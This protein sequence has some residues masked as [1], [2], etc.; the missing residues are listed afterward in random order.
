V[1]KRFGPIFFCWFFLHSSA[2]SKT[3]VEMQQLRLPPT[4]KQLLV[5]SAKSVIPEPHLQPIVTVNGW[6]Q[7]VRVQKTM[8]FL[9]INDGS[10]TDGLQAVVDSSF[11]ARFADSLHTGACVSLTGILSQVGE[12]RHQ[13]VELAVQQIKVLGT[14]DPTVSLVENGAKLLLGS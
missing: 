4:I 9:H 10:C 3:L 1:K 13:A 6:L 11:I 12:K 2:L 8:T 14:A 7:T 5:K